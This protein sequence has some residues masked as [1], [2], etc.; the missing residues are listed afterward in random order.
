MFEAFI[1]LFPDAVVIV[2]EA[3]TMV[4]VNAQAGRMFG[5]APRALLGKPLEILL[6]ER[7]RKRHAALRAH[8]S[9]APEI[10]PMGAGMELVA[11]RKD[12]SEFPVDIM[13]SPLKTAGGSSTLAVVRDI[14]ERKRAEQAL[15]ESKEMLSVSLDSARMGAWDL[16]LASDASVRNLRHDQIFGYETPQRDWGIKRFLQ[17]VPTEDLKT[18]RKALEEAYTRGHLSLECRIRRADGSIRWINAQGRCS[19]DANGAPVRMSGTVMDV[20]ERKELENELKRSALENEDLYNNAPCGYHQCDLTEKD[21]V[22]LRMNDTELKWLGYRREEV[23]G[24]LRRSDVLTPRSVKAFAGSFPLLLSRGRIKSLELEMIRKDGSVFPVLHDST[25]VTDQNGR[26]VACRGIVVDLTERRAAEEVRAIRKQQAAQTKFINNISHEFRTPLAAIRGFSE[27]LRT[28]GFDDT[29]KRHGFVRTIERHAVRLTSL[30]DEIL[31]LS[32]HQSDAQAHQPVAVD[33][34]RWFREFSGDIAPLA[35]KRGVSVRADFAPGMTV[36]I[37]ET[38][39]QRIFQ[40]LCANAI[41]YTRPGGKVLVTGRVRG[42]EAAVSVED[43]GIGISAE[44]LPRLFDSFF[45]AEAA[46]R[47]KPKGTGLGLPIVKELVES[48]GGK[49]AVKSVPG[50]GSTFLFTLPLGTPARRQGK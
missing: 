31:E 33:L 47:M 11:R 15:R 35:K 7:F 48:N 12:G 43:T 14:S 45:R 37:S 25:A 44:D 18:V 49:I 36:L 24:K 6:P 13:L 1:E 2:G 34:A 22:F 26:L 8:Y 41:N 39:I 28:G 32:H 21:G 19:L 23:V 5:Y 50:K 40:N 46:K 3:G 16:D 20:T 38:A 10:R 17:H 27:T 30:V 4:R 9:A 42:K 29:R